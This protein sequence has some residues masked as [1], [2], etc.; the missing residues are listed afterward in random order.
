MTPPRRGIWAET[1]P[2]EALADPATY[3][4]LARFGADVALAVRPADVER[5]ATW[6]DLAASHGVR[7]SLWP[8]IDDASGRWLST[9]SAEPFR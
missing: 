1:A 7:A 8:M 4:A 6:V 5:V 9:A 3:R 2:P